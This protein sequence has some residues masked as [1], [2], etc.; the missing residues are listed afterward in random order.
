MTIAEALENVQQIQIRAG[1]AE[2]YETA[3]REL[4]CRTGAPVLRL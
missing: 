3:A 4:A 1:S 2:V